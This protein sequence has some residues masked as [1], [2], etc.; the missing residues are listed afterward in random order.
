M[1]DEEYRDGLTENKIV[2]DA[3]K[4]HNIVKIVQ[5]YSP[6][7][8]DLWLE[9]QKVPVD[10]IFNYLSGALLFHLDNGD[11]VGF[12]GDTL[13]CSVVSWFDT[14]NGQEDDTNYYDRDWY[15][16]M[17]SADSEY[18]SIDNWSHMINE[19]IISVTVLVIDQGEKKYFND[20]LQRLVILETKKGD[21]VLSYMLFDLLGGP[22]FPFTRKAD[23]PCDIWNKAKI[24]QL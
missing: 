12:A 17:D 3:L 7:V 21:M 1:R 15:S 10:E 16:Y 5:A 22:S 11:V 18:S 6:G 13:K 9:E 24:V 4:K 14:Y 19:K 20:S 2:V 23:I 8:L